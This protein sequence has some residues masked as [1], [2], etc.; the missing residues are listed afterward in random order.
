M[1]TDEHVVLDRNIAALHAERAKL[2]AQV[3]MRDRIASA[4]GRF[5]GS[6]EFIYIHVAIYG[7]WILENSGAI[8]IVGPWDPSLLILT[9]AIALETI[10]LTTFVLIN[11]NRTAAL[12]KRRADLNLQISLLTEHEVTKL[13]T[14]TSAIAAKLNVNTSVDTDLP[15][16]ERDIAPE[17]VLEKLAKT[18]D[19]HEQSRQ[20][21]R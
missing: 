12:E 10:F 1:S 9:L 17:L 21:Q 15:E 11:Q 16:L 2:D 7:F 20:A 4:I 8:K 13:I 19:G 6:I 3:T 18:E 14:L 5:A